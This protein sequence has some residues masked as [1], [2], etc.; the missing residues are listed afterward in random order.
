MITKNSVVKFQ[1]LIVNHKSQAVK[2][3]PV[4]SQSCHFVQSEHKQRVFQ[5]IYG[6]GYLIYGKKEPLENVLKFNFG[7]KHR[8]M[9]TPE[10]GV[11]LQVRLSS[12]QCA[13]L[14][15]RSVALFPGIVFLFLSQRCSF[16]NHPPVNGFQR[17]MLHLMFDRVENAPLTVMKCHQVGLLK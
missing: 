2:S 3:N 8:Q 14:F 16:L 11:R 13:L 10:D 4:V 12:S 1:N 6:S 5:R 7:L 17:K 15:S 9:T